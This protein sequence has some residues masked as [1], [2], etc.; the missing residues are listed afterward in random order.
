MALSGGTVFGTC[1]TRIHDSV[2]QGTRIFVLS[3]FDPSN[4][5]ITDE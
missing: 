1:T 2:I 5:V 4:I 3:L